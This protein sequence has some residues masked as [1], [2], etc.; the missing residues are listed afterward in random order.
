MLV[1]F[2][3][4]LACCF[5]A[6]IALSDLLGRRFRPL[7][8][9]EVD[10]VEACDVGLSNGALSVSSSS[11]LLEVEIDVEVGE[12][13]LD[14]FGR[15]LGEIRGEQR[16]PRV[17]DAD[18]EEVTEVLE[19]AAAE[20]TSTLIGLS[21]EELASSVRGRTLPRRLASSSSKTSSAWLMAS[22]RLRSSLGASP[23]GGPGWTT[24]TGG[25]G[26]SGAA[27]GAA[28]AASDDVT[29]MMTRPFSGRFMARTAVAAGHGRGS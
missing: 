3:R 7:L 5:N 8:G 20:V 27:A 15:V 9:V 16:F 21:T 17:D 18:V 28:S 11:T 10:E 2:F 24:S 29:G 4:L 22:S 25:A 14:D 13:R 26:G 23:G 12:A 19:V 1:F 6:V